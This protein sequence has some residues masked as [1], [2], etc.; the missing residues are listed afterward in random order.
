M[1]VNGRSCML[2]EGPVCYTTHDYTWGRLDC[3]CY[4]LED[5]TSILGDH[6]SQLTTPRRHKELTVGD[7]L[8]GQRNTT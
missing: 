5:A 4:G 7:I 3:L 6:P 2:M 8:D 1:Y